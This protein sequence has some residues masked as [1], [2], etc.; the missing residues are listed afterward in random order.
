[1]PPF[2]PQIPTIASADFKP[3]DLTQ[4]EWFAAWSLIGPSVDKTL[5]AGYIGANVPPIWMVIT[6]AF[7]QG[8]TW[9]QQLT[10]ERL[11]RTAQQPEQHPQFAAEG[12]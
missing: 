6:G 3:F 2:G 8:L 11:G 5:G 12:I 4:D 10:E 9:G 7:L 1:M